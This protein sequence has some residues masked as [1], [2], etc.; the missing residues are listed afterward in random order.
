MV[1]NHATT[2]LF[3]R[4]EV[5][6]TEYILYNQNKQYIVYHTLNTQI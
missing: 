2:Q 5:P 6:L 3:D 4:R 1:A